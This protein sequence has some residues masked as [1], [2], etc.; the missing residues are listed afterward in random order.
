MKR[1]R[2]RS[3]YRERPTSSDLSF[4]DADPILFRPHSVESGRGRATCLCGGIGAMVKPSREEADL[5]DTQS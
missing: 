3:P 4:Q 2:P 1:E 5:L